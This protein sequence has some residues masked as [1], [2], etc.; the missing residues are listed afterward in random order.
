MSQ[1]TVHGSPQARMIAEPSRLLRLNVVTEALSRADAEYLQHGEADDHNRDGQDVVLE[2]FFALLQAAVL[3]DLVDD[4]VLA[5]ARL[6]AHTVAALTILQ[7]IRE[8]AA[9]RHSA[10]FY[11]R[12]DFGAFEVDVLVP[13]V[14]QRHA[15]AFEPVALYPV[16]QVLEVFVVSIVLDHE[17]QVLLDL[18]LHFVLVHEDEDAERELSEEDDAQSKAELK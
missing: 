3:V 9:R 12:V 7:V 2:P 6:V 11:P 16:N 4:D 14:G 10:R 13:V 15:A 1:A 5:D 17:L 18:V 8:A